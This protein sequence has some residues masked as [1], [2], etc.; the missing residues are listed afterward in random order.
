[1]CKMKIIGVYQWQNFVNVHLI[2][3]IFDL[4]PEEVD[5]YEISQ[6]KNDTM[7]WDESYLDEKGE[8]IISNKHEWPAGKSTTRLVFFFHDLNFEEALLT[9]F[10]PIAVPKPTPIP[11]RLNEIIFYDDPD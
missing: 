6:A 3:M 1:M 7:P 11:R 10:G 2:E 5:L 4:P 9:P 8:Q